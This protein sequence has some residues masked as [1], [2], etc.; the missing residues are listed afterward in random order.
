ME[1]TGIVIPRKQAL[2]LLSVLA[3]AGCPTRSKSL[4]TDGG[5]GSDGGSDGSHG[6]GD[7][8][9][10][11]ASD[12]H[13]GGSLPTLQISSPA[14]DT[15]TNSSVTVTVGASDG[16]LVS[17]VSVYVDQETTPLKT[18][19]TPYTFSW[20]TT[21]VS[22]GSHILT[23]KA[24]VNGQAIA[25]ASVT[26]HVDRTAPTFTTTPAAN[27]L[28]VALSDPIELVF[29]EALDPT[30]V[31]TAAV[32]L[33]SGGSLLNTTASLAADMRTVTVTLNSHSSLLF[34]ATITESVLSTV[35]DLAGNAVG[36]APTWS[37]T[38]PLWVKLPVLAGGGPALALDP[39]GTAIVSSLVDTFTTTQLSVV[40]YAPGATWDLGFGSPPVTAGLSVTAASVAVDSD[41]S[42][43]VGWSQD[44]V[45]A[46]HWNGTSWDLLAG[47]ADATADETANP[48]YLSTIA[49]D[50]TGAPLVGWSEQVET[51][52]YGYVARWSKPTWQI[53]PLGTRAGAGGPVLLVNSMG[54]PVGLFPGASGIPG[55]QIQIYEAGS[56]LPI[57]SPST[58]ARNGLGMLFAFALDA[59][60]ESVALVE[61][62]DSVS[63]DEVIHV[64]VFR[65]SL[66]MDLAP[67]L[68]TTAAE[69]TIGEV[70]VALDGGGS[71]FILWTQPDATSSM[72]I[73]LARSDGLG[74]D[75]TYGVL[76]GISA[77]STDATF[78]SLAIDKN[79]T[80]TVSW[81]ETDPS[82]GLPNVYVWKSNL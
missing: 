71:P 29:S 13:G 26:V 58:G 9:G 24:T 21:T 65:S 11:G 76:N 25:S 34:P 42:P 41:G 18:A 64:E 35:K 15:Y 50:S 6:D 66:W 72:S 5:S 56:W 40:R 60:D 63:G 32:T 61:T 57:A 79:G 69:G 54:A 82:T 4:P 43:T 59:Q 22:E 3:L 46:A 30:S 10:D 1:P 68:S 7:G 80:P 20:D 16:L 33:T 55:P 2:V 49:L 27:T 31:T 51:D 67:S 77:A 73:H 53:L 38:A 70:H 81:T 8:D 45:Y 14:P 48:P 19:S 12:A 23:A 62:I 36:A 37:W 17:G 47:Q 75:T 39:Q 44:H 28:N 74:W 78:T 52:T